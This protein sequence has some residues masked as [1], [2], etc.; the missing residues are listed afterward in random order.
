MGKYGATVLILI[1][2]A[3]NAASLLALAKSHM[4]VPVASVPAPPAP[5][6]V[7]TGKELQLV[8][9]RGDTYL[10]AYSLEKRQ[11]DGSLDSIEAVLEL[12]PR[13]NKS[14]RIMLTTNDKEGSQI[15]LGDTNG[16]QLYMTI[17]SPDKVFVIITGQGSE[18]GI[19]IDVKTHIV[20][21]IV[22]KKSTVLFKW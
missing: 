21:R 11:L 6:E 10:R 19:L 9:S 15:Y 20:E 4:N 17:A 8:T 14:S 12:Q 13:S 7:I 3:T 2:V 5:M 16:C 22:D 1:L 18:V